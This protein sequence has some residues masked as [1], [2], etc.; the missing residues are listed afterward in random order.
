[1]TTTNALTEANISEIAKRLGQ[2]LN[3]IGKARSI[4]KLAEKH[5][6][7]TEQVEVVTSLVGSH[8]ANPAKVSNLLER[9]FSVEAVDAFYEVR[10]IMS[11]SKK[12]A[13]GKPHTISISLETLAEFVSYF[14]D[15]YD[16]TNPDEGLI[17]SDIEGIHK[18]LSGG[19]S[20]TPRDISLLRLIN[21]G[22]KMGC[23]EIDTILDSLTTKFID[24]DEF[25]TEDDEKSV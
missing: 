19:G 20:E 6:L 7:T 17:A 10:D 5:A 11:E 2:E 15:R 25:D 3:I 14:A 13:H 23:V 8:R 4:A 12:S 18:A 24:A 9:N 1:M 21:E 22:R 16:L